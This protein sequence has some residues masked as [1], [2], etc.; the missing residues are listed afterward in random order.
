[1]DTITRSRRFDVNGEPIMVCYI[2]DPTT[3]K[4]VYY[5][6]DDTTTGPIIDAD[7]DRA[8]GQMNGTLAPIRAALTA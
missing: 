5:Y 8:I 3:A 4:R 2:G 1:M 7:T 6:L